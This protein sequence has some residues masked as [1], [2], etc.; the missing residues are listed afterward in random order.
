MSFK[1][2][3]KKFTFWSSYWKWKQKKRK[4]AVHIADYMSFGQP[5]KMSNTEIIAG[6]LQDRLLSVCGSLMLQKI[7][8][9][10]HTEEK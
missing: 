8:H 7:H 3:L 6:F 1:Y 2:D 4:N 5:S 9:Y 10:A